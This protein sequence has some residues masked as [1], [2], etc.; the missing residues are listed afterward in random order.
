MKKIINY[1]SGF[2]IAGGYSIIGLVFVGII[3]PMLFIVSVTIFFLMALFGK[4]KL[5]IQTET[6]EKT[7]E[8]VC[9]NE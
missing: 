5:D 6:T 4:L 7:N 1:L 8:D 2:L 3:F 9:S